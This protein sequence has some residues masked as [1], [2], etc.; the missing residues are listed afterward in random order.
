MP[1]V[2]LKPFWQTTNKTTC[3]LYHGHV[4][5]V[6]ARL[7]RKSVH[8][9]VTSPPYWGLRDYGTGM[10]EGG[11]PA[12]DHVE[13]KATDA[14][15]SSMLGP[16]RHEGIT[17]P[18]TNAAFKA[19]A[20]QYASLCGKCGATR[21][22][23]QIG[24]EHSPDCGT[25]GQAQCGR[26]FVCNMVG[27]FREVKGVLRDDGVAWLNL[28]DTYAG[29]GAGGPGKNN[30]YPGYRDDNRAHRTSPLGSGNLVGVPWRVALA[31]QADGWVLRADLPWVK[32]SPMPES[33]TSRPA[34]ALEYVFM[35]TKGMNYFYDHDAV[36]VKSKGGWSSAGFL[37]DS[38][39]DKRSDGKTAATGASRSNR[40]TDLVSEDAGRNFRNADLF[41]ESLKTPHGLV[42]AEGEGP[43][44]LDV[45]SKG[46]EGAHFACFPPKL[47]TPL[48]KASTSEKGCCAAC[49]APWTRVTEKTKLRRERPNEYV[50][51]VGDDGTGDSIGNGVAGVASRTLGWEPEC[52]CKQGE[53]SVVP[54]TVL[55]PFVGSGTVCEV[56]LD[57][58]L[59]SVG[60]DL[61]ETYLTNNVVTRVRGRLIRR[62]EGG[63]IPKT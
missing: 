6:L 55:D 13:R 42:V 4:T 44:A 48:I 45:T 46:Y 9:V 61:N 8:C 3:R 58:D 39:K 15:K 35:L 41:Y 7:P 54:C 1:I 25:H 17:L 49:G 56:A 59:R 63:L 38:D 5:K 60:I 27:V 47:V 30:D 28:G 12:C 14:H 16:K 31:L 50:K 24:S 29:G 19:T 43:V 32:R 52:I 36:K 18:E 26:C 62:G 2:P 40:S 20:R 51:R 22:D 11:S 57:H 23:L 53:D 10:W 37:P 34:K 33:V 21:T